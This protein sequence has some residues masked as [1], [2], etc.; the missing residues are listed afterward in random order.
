M[1]ANFHIAALRIH[2]SEATKGILDDLGGFE[3]QERGEVFLKVR[4]RDVN[5]S[6]LFVYLGEHWS[7]NETLFVNCNHIHGGGRGGGGGGEN[8]ED[9]RILC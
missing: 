4:K 2:I 1:I 8:S 5:L 7:A 6:L 9:T 3:V